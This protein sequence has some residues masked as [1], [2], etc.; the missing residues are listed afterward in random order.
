[1]KP[2]TKPRERLWCSAIQSGKS[3]GKKKGSGESKIVGLKRGLRKNQTSGE[4]CIHITGADARG[5]ERNRFDQ[6][7]S[8]QGGHVA[9]FPRA[10][11]IDDHEI[12]HRLER[13]QRMMPDAARVVHALA[14]AAQKGEGFA[15]PAIGSVRGH[16]DQ[17]TDLA[18]RHEDLAAQ[19]MALDFRH[20]QGKPHRLAAEH[21]ERC[22]AALLRYVYFREVVEPH[23]GAIV[24]R[25]R[26]RSVGLD[27]VA[28]TG[29][30]CAGQHSHRQDAR[31]AHRGPPGNCPHSLSRLTPPSGMMLKRTCVT[32]PSS[33][34]W[35][36]NACTA[37]IDSGC[38]GSSTG[39]NMLCVTSASSGTFFALVAC[40]EHRSG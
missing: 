16:H 8:G 17:N 10:G 37:S 13:E 23:G 30:R 40:N 14:S 2:L 9:V 4:I 34:S 26:V 20:L 29:E 11:A 25:E 21:A 15:G 24:D 18:H 1:M 33:S 5:S 31:R 22:T 19:G 27:H 36:A 12:A 7:F 28:E 3:G 32:A 35:P 39:Q 6:V 38:S